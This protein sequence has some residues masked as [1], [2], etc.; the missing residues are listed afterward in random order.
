LKTANSVENP[1]DE[2]IKLPSYSNQK[3]WI[4]SSQH[5][6]LIQPGWMFKLKLYIWSCY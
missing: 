3:L 1:L 6:P 5:L 2:D 4:T